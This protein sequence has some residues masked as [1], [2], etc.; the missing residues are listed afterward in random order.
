MLSRVKSLDR[1]F[2][3]N[4]WHSFREQIHLI[5]NMQSAT[6]REVLIVIY[7][8]TGRLTCYIMRDECD[9][10]KCFPRQDKVVGLNIFLRWG[11]AAAQGEWVLMSSTINLHF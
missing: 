5:G 8:C 2:T 6:V 1:S 4:L 9:L 7:V 3:L 11:K 10:F